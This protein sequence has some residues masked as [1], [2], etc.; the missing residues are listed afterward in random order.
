M[1]LDSE[2]CGVGAR[3][4]QGAGR[5]DNGV[6]HGS[7]PGSDPIPLRAKGRDARLGVACRARNER[8]RLK[9][10]GSNILLHKVDSYRQLS[11]AWVMRGGVVSPG[12]RPASRLRFPPM[13]GR[14]LNVG[15][16]PCIAQRLI[17]IERQP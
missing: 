2:E 16:K 12:T 10:P 15:I 9:G 14:C 3:S 8:P 5:E 11:L 1:A 6:R 7:D 13:A 17:L 4:G